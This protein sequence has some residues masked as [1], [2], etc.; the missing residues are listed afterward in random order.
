M[1]ERWTAREDALLTRLYRA[2]APMRHIAEALERSEDAVNARRSALRLPARRLPAPWSPREDALLQA[3]ARA[4]LS[5]PMVAERLGRPVGQ[6]R[7]RRRVLGLV[8]SPSRPYAPAEDAALCALFERGGSLE[9]MAR[10]LGRTPDALRLRAAKL[11]LYRPACRRRWSPGEDAAIRDGYDSGLSCGEIARGL[12]GRTAAGVAA[13]ARQL[14]LATHARRWTTADDERLRRLASSHRPQDMARLLGRT[15]DA[16]RQRARKLAVAL[17]PAS[18]PARAG[19]RWTPQ[20]D[21]LLRMHPGLNPATLAELLGRSDRAV[22]IRLAKLGLRSGRERSPHRR[23]TPLGRLTPGEQAL[24]D[25]E[26]RGDAPRRRL[27]VARR[28]GLPASAVAPG[29]ARPTTRGAD[30][31]AP[32]TLTHRAEGARRT[33]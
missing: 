31:A 26:L 17:P 11:D 3:A 21:E 13:R 12:R 27:L 18:A 29:A 7:W 15:P 24:L 8:S 10:T 33:M 16:L 1:G 30:A 9:Q 2:G 28:L 6:V 25:R 14:G 5:A 23:T 32:E 4:G 19:E 20:D 22:T